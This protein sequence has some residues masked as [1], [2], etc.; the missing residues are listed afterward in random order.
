MNVLGPA[1]PTGVADRD[2]LVLSLKV[3]ATSFLF[4]G[5]ID[6]AAEKEL[7]DSGCLG[8]V[9]VLKVASHGSAEGTSDAFLEATTPTWAIYS[10]GL[11]NGYGHP[12][13]A[14]LARLREHRA[15]VLGTDR[16]GTIVFAEDETAGTLLA[17]WGDTFDDR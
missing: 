2:S 1:R 17:E 6:K 9:D 8:P 10:A 13:P 14:T 4:T 3:G 15:E 5:D 12:A 16:L 11:R 7:V